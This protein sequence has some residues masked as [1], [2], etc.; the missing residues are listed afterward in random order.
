[1]TIA[2]PQQQVKTT[3]RLLAPS[4]AMWMSTLVFV[5]S[6]YMGCAL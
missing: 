2:M 6:S 5:E 3:R 1:M 4:E